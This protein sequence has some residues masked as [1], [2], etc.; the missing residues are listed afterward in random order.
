MFSSIATTSSSQESISSNSNEL[1]TSSSDNHIVNNNNNVNTFSTAMRDPLRDRI[2]DELKIKILAASSLKNNVDASSLK[3]P[4]C[5]PTSATTST[6]TTVTLTTTTTNKSNNISIVNNNNN[7]TINNKNGNNPTGSYN[8]SPKPPIPAPFRTRRNTYH[9]SSSSNNNNVN[10]HH[11]HHNDNNKPCIPPPHHNKPYSNNKNENNNN[12]PTTNTSTSPPK[13]TLISFNN[14]SSTSPPKAY[15]NNNTIKVPLTP[16]ERSQTEISKPFKPNNFNNQQQ[17]HAFHGKNNFIPDQ[18]Y[19]KLTFQEDRKVVNN[20]QNSKTN[21]KNNNKM[22]NNI[23]KVEEG[24]KVILPHNANNY[25]NANIN[26]QQQQEEKELLPFQQFELNLKRLQQQPPFL[27]T[28]F[29]PLN[30]SQPFSFNYNINNN[31]NNNRIQQQED[32]DTDDTDNSDNDDDVNNKNLLFT[33][34]RQTLHKF[35]LQTLTQE[36]KQN[37]QLFLKKIEKLNLNKDKETIAQ[38][39]VIPQRFKYIYL[40][41]KHNISIKEQLYQQDQFFKLNNNNQKENCNVT[42]KFVL[43]ELHDNQAMKFIRQLGHKILNSTIT[44]KESPFGLFHTSLII[45]D[46]LLEWNDSSIVT[47]RRVSSS[48]AIFAL[49]LCVLKEVKDIHICLD[50]ISKV[51]CK[52]NS[53]VIYDNLKANCQHF[54]TELLLELGIN[55]FDKLSVGSKLYIERLQKYGVCDMTIGLSPTLQEILKIKDTTSLTFH[56]HEELDYIVR[57]ILQVKKEYFLT[58]EGKD[59]EMLLKSFDRAFWLRFNSNSNKEREIINGS[60]EVNE[61]I[62]KELEAC[63]PLMSKVN[64]SC[65][66][67]N[68]DCLCP[69]NDA[70]ENELLGNNNYRNSI[71]L[72]ACNWGSYFPKFPKR[73]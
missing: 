62:K 22:I 71:T 45:G 31:N 16:R 46:R 25:N 20:N 68:G 39:N 72:H 28:T 26:N 64:N 37:V 55:V 53:G 54:T 38:D 2:N 61:K 23:Q 18:F 50:K 7:N 63:R 21:N 35:S 32:Y 56:S 30:N 41:P 70:N 17:Q 33:T 40:F 3:S 49:D 36:E 27:P 1:I 60:G 34:K 6:S 24:F 73:H 14:T 67:V 51:C 19:D 47:V 11:H 44:S 4:T 48:K 69:F 12:K 58:Q 65:G 8:N 42:I 43:T 66:S 57:M 59:L 29:N 52:W 15:N 10:N 13:P 5:L 9:T